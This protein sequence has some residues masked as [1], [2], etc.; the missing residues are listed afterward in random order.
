MPCV[1]GY[2]LV[3]PH[4]ASKTSPDGLNGC[5][6]HPLMSRPSATKSTV[7]PPSPV[8]VA[9]YVRG[10][11]PSTGFCDDAIVVALDRRYETVIQPSL[12]SV[13]TPGALP[14]DE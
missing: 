7:P 4:V 1:P 14:A 5:A 3:V 13:L 11:R 9:V 10:W 8:T 6:P 12:P 2:V